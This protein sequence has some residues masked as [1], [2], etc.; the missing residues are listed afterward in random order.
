MRGGIE[1]QFGRG[2]QDVEESGLTGGALQA[3]LTQLGGQR[4][5]ALGELQ[6]GLGQQVLGSVGQIAGVPGKGGLQDLIQTQS[7][8]EAQQAML[9]GQ[10]YQAGGGLLTALLT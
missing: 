5:G 2:R 1:S 8:A 6:T 4:A 10:M 9:T 7:A 3:A